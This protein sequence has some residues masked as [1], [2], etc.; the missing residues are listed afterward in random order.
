MCAVAS[1]SSPGQ[2]PSVAAYVTGTGATSGVTAARG[3]SC[4]LSSRHG[5]CDRRHPAVLSSAKWQQDGDRLYDFCQ[6]DQLEHS[7]LAFDAVER[8]SK[9]YAAGRSTRIPNRSRGSGRGGFQEGL[10]LRGRALLAL[11]YRRESSGRRLAQG[12]C[13]RVASLANGGPRQC[14]PGRRSPQRPQPQGLL[15]LRPRVPSLRHGARPDGCRPPQGLGLLAR[16]RSARVQGSSARR[17]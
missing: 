15:L 16:S 14:R 6:R 7:G 1:G 5:D 9:A 12:H 11:R 17:P 2:R 8:G 13:G 10:S 3:R 4:W